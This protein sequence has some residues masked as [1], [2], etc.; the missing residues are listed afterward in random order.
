MASLLYR[1]AILWF[2]CIYLTDKFFFLGIVLAL[3]LV[4]LQILLP[5]FKALRFVMAG[6]N[7]GRK[8]NRAITS[9]TILVAL[10]LGILGFLPIPSYTLAEGVVW[11][12]EKAQIKAKRD[13]FAGFL[14]KCNPISLS[15][16]AR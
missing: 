1:L 5:T 9:A 2:I 7:F 6:K 10:V 15:K 4:V 8:K 14:C 13:G 3:W 16:K 11:L 12:P